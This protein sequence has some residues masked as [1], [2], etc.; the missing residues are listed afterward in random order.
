M[1][2]KKKKRRRGREGEKKDN[3]GAKRSSAEEGKEREGRKRPR[4]PVEKKK[5]KDEKGE[6]DGRWAMGD[7]RWDEWM[8]SHVKPTRPPHYSLPS[9]TALPW[10]LL[11]NNSTLFLA[12]PLAGFPIEKEINLVWTSSVGFFC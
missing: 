5:R 8:T 3:D 11:D 2:M 1:E 12:K 7:G 9:P 10:Y 4:L 6:G